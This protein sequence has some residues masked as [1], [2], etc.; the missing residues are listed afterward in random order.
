MRGVWSTSS[1]PKPPLAFLEVRDGR[2]V[3]E[4][5]AQHSL[6]VAC[7]AKQLFEERVKVLAGR[8]LPSPTQLLAVSACLHDLGKASRYYQG[9]KRVE[10]VLRNG[11]SLTFA[12]HH[13]STAVLLNLAEAVDTPRAAPGSSLRGLLRL[14][15]HVALRHHQAMRVSASIEELDENKKRVLVG[16]VRG[17]N[18]DWVKE[19]LD[20]CGRA[21]YLPED[22]VLRVATAA[23][24]LAKA[25]DAEI[26]ALAESI[27]RYTPPEKELRL[28]ASVA[29]AVIVADYAVSLVARG[30]YS[31]LVEVWERGLPQLTVEAGR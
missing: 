17:L 11:G 21:G 10:S 13:V 20:A 25:G 14:A 16:S 1:Q 12:L 6:A 2:P 30:G 26:A 4:G 9:E 24:G 27:A 22:V 7:L 23:E 28:V 8:D 29:G 5:L 15:G 3:Y 31:G 19:V 18:P